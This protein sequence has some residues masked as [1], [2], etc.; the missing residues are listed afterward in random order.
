MINTNRLK[1]KIEENGITIEGI[2][3][4]I[5]IHKCTFYRK[6]NNG[7]ISFTIGEVNDITKILKLSSEEA[8]EIF[9]CSM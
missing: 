2:A 3:E 4:K 1:Q 9:L 7:G 8:M 6:I 5:G